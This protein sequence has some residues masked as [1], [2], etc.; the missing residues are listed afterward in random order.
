MRVRSAI[1]GAFFTSGL[2]ISAA[3]AGPIAD[4]NQKAGITGS[5]TAGDDG[6][7]RF[8]GAVDLYPESWSIKPGDRLG[9][10]VRSTTTFDVRV[11]RL[12]WYGGAGAREV[13]VSTGN[14][15]IAQPYPTPDPKF[16]LAEAR[17]ATNVTVDTA[18][19]TPGLYVARAEQ[20]SGK[21]AL[22]FFTVRDD[23][24]KLPFLLVVGTH[25]HQA[26]NAWPGPAGSGATSE[27]DPRWVGKSLYG[28][29]SSKAHPS[30]SIGELRQAV[31]VSFDRPYFVG[32]GTADVSVYEYPFV[33]WA[34]REGI[35]L[36]VATDMDLHLDPSLL[37]G[38]KL[39]IF[40]GHEEYVTRRMFDHALAARAA[41]VNFLFLSGDTWSWQVRVEAGQGPFS[42]LVGYKES[43]VKD[44]EQRLAFS[45]KNA[46]RIEEAKTHY[47]LVSRGWKNLEHDPAA[48]ID[49]RRPGMLLT[50]VQSAG[51]IRDGAGVPMHGGLY[52]WADLV[53]TLKDHWIY[54]GTGLRNGDRIPH[55]FGYEVDSTLQSKPEFDRFRPA[56]QLIFGAIRQSADGIVKG[57]TASFRDPSGAEVV[58]MGAIYTAWALD[59]WGWRSGGF[60]A[61]GK[62]APTSPTYQ[63][64]MRNVVDRYAGGVAPEFDAGV[65]LDGGGYEAGPIAEPEEVEKDTGIES[66]TEPVDLPPPDAAADGEGDVAPNPNDAEPLPDGAPA[67][68]AGSDPNPAPATPPVVA[69]SD[70]CSCATQGRPAGA[71]LSSIAL[72]L[73]SIAA[74]RRRRRG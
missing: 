15:A 27:D 21:Q 58:S 70:G 8:A 3:H 26:Y 69:E 66:E 30:D 40:S 29:N 23:G 17:W 52:P 20:P 33:R 22:T 4:E 63:K 49:E 73:A 43:W 5:W 61:A 55:V 48:G 51:I 62:P 59:D 12:G 28:F 72:A 6:T 67:P 60:A 7:A 57:S 56:G 38:R 42:T 71:S 2:A 13:A 54:A 44:P 11:F 37:S 46:G 14:A 53:V 45:L 64:M 47:R 34:E 19:W 35:D 9:L 24:A 10:K 32:G 25:T 74:M 18:G 41:G 16:G 50:G 65:A 39:V 68:D 36:A 31:K 1:F